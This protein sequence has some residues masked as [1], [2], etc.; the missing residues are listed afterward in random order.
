MKLKTIILLG[1]PFLAGLNACSTKKVDLGIEGD[2]HKIDYVSKADRRSLE[3]EDGN[4]AR[5]MRPLRG[6][7]P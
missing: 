4:G 1:L 6:Y 7:S 2:L 5:R 3:L